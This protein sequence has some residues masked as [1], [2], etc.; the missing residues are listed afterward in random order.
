MS[1]QYERAQKLNH[2]PAPEKFNLEK[3]PITS[4]KIKFCMCNK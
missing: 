2:L 4:K 1:R 3:Y